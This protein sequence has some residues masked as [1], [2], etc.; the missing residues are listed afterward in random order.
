MKLQQ[1]STFRFIFLP[2]SFYIE[3]KSLQSIK[4]NMGCYK[5]GKKQER[6]GTQR[7]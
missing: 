6:K 5:L 1:F 2:V 3:G 4:S 7:A